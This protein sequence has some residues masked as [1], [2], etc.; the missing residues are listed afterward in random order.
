MLEV[1]SFLAGFQVPDL[2]SPGQFQSPPPLTS[3]L[4]SGVNATPHTSP[5]WP[6]SVTSLQVA[7]PPDFHGPV[8]QAGGDGTCRPARRRPSRTSPSLATSKAV[9]SRQ[10]PGPGAAPYRREPA[11]ASVLPSAEKARPLTQLLCPVSRPTSA[12]LA[13][14]QS[15]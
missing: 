14:S 15:G 8:T 13:T 10:S 6:V 11:E 4:P 12:P 9:F 2:T 7:M 5:V 1:H 3:V